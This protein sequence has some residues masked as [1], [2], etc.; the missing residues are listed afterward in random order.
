MTPR[1]TH[2]HRKIF[3]IGPNSLAL[4]IKQKHF[5]KERDNNGIII[6]GRDCFSKRKYLAT[7]YRVQIACTGKRP[8][9]IAEFPIATIRHISGHKTIPKQTKKK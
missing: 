7:E 8:K 9:M 4:K 3:R 5:N 6:E 2:K 1:G